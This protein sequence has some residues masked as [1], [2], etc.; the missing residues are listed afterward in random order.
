MIILCSMRQDYHNIYLALIVLLSGNFGCKDQSSENSLVNQS[1]PSGKNE[2]ILRMVQP[3]DDSFDDADLSEVERREANT[4]YFLPYF[5]DYYS[6]EKPFEEGIKGTFFRDSPD[7][8]YLVV[9]KRVPGKSC[10]L[11]GTA[12]TETLVMWSGSEGCRENQGCGGFAADDNG[13]KFQ[14]IMRRFGSREFEFSLLEE[15]GNVGAGESRPHVMFKPL[16]KVQLD[17]LGSRHFGIK[18]P[19]PYDPSPFSRMYTFATFSGIETRGEFNFQFQPIQLVRPGEWGWWRDFTPNMSRFSYKRDPADP[20]EGLEERER[21]IDQILKP[22]MEYGAAIKALRQG[23]E[24]TGFTED[25]SIEMYL[26][27]AAVYY[28]FINE[29]NP[30]QWK[31][32]VIDNSF[33]T[34][35]SQIKSIFDQAGLD[36][37]LNLDYRFA[38]CD[39]FDSCQN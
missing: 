12:E 28:G 35:F 7:V 17:V 9:L 19:N 36:Y 3:D 32:T 1:A 15:A 39:L 2:R 37:E 22:R 6:R 5:D 34:S 38:N 29:S 31:D 27:F 26:N 21:W 8:S 25:K 33:Y 10:R 13:K 16:E 20:E 14:M 11:F 24:I 23:L 4:C 30:K 18:N